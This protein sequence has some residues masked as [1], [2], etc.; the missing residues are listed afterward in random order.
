MTLNLGVR[1]EYETPLRDPENRLTRYADFSQGLPALEAAAGALPQEALALR[2]RPLSYTGA[3]IFTDSDNRGMW[4]SPKNIILP[5]VG[6]AI[7]LDN[8]TALRI[9]YARYATPSIQERGSIDVL[10]STPYPGFTATTNPLTP[11]Q[12]LPRSLLADPFPNG[13]TNNN[14]LIEPFGK[15]NGIYAAVGSAG[16]NPE[17]VFF[18][19]DWK[20]GIND[21]IN[22]SLQRELVSRIVVDATFFMNFGRNHAIDAQINRADPRIAYAAQSATTKSVA[23]PYFGIAPSIMPGSLANS[24]NLAVSQLLRPFPFYNDIEESALP[25]A[26][27]YYKAMQFKLQRPFANGFNFLLGYNYNRGRISQWY[28]EVDEYDQNKTLQKDS[29]QGQVVT[30]GSIYELPFGRDRKFGRDMHKGLDYVVGGW[31][32]SG[33]FRYVSGQLLQFPT[34]QLLSD[35]VK[36]DNPTRQEWFNTAAFARQPAF[37]RRNNPWF[38][39][40]VRG[41]YFS[42]VDLT[43]NKKFNVTEKLGLEIRME[44][45]NLTNSF[46]GANPNTDVTNGAFGIVNN[47]LATSSG[48]EFQYSA[49]FFW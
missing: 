7:R 8:K 2:N 10:G 5:R 37:T 33:I 20:A 47:K 29:D 13:G 12:G 43:L 21:R 11:I 4:T 23:N 25:M 44:A 39:D 19:Q 41:P 36:L 14:P 38:V 24:R 31:S 1:Y 26:D 48:R 16:G 30:L 6:L 18:H 22:F 27:V 49:R 32:V 40:G 42:N 46:M 45:Y 28:D 9:G 34:Q 17:G 3:W 35:D 15:A